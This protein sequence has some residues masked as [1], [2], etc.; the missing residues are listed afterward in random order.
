MPMYFFS[1]LIPPR[2]SFAFDMNDSERALMEQHAKYWSRV[3]ADGNAVVFGPVAD[4]NGPF[5][6]LVLEVEREE[7]AQKLIANDPVNQSDLG[8]KFQTYPMLSAVTRKQV[9]ERPL[10]NQDDRKNDQAF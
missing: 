7:D 10:A 5:G 2:P 9:L 1:K 3:A 8:F 6:L 4:P